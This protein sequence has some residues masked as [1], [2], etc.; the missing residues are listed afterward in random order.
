MGDIRSVNYCFYATLAWGAA[1]YGLAGLQPHQELCQLVLLMLCSVVHHTDLKS[2]ADLP[3]SDPLVFNVI[4][5]P[6][7]SGER[8]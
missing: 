6:E 2:V 1:R 8:L 3:L 5:C 4:N 7:I